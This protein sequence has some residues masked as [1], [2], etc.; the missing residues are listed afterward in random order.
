[1][2]IVPWGEEMVPLSEWTK[3]PLPAAYPNFIGASPS[4]NFL[5]FFDGAKLLAVHL[6]EGRFDE[7]FEVRFVSGSPVTSKSYDN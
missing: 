7:P 3:V 4:G 6:S 5:Y 2:Y 1:M